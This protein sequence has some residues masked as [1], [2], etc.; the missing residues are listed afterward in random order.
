MADAEMTANLMA[1]LRQKHGVR[2][3]S[4]KHRQSSVGAELA[5]DDGLTANIDG[6]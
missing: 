3:L 6:D 5:R 4:Q 2:E 1:H